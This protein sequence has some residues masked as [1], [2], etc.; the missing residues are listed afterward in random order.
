ML[1]YVIKLSIYTDMFSFL[2]EILKLTFI[3]TPDGIDLRHFIY[4]RLFFF[5]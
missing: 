5:Y 3:S 4:S 2:D 1:K